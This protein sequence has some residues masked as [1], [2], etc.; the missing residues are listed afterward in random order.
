MLSRTTTPQNSVYSYD[1]LDRITSDQIDGNN[2]FQYDY[3]LNHN[4]QSKTQLASLADGYDYQLGTNRLARQ[5]T[6]TTGTLPQIASDRQYIYSDTN[7]I[8]QVY[9]NGLLT[10]EYIY[11]DNRQRTRKTTYENSVSPATTRIT[12]YHYD[13]MGY[14]I[15]ETDQTGIPQKDY[16][17]AEG[18]VPMAQI[19]IN[20][21]IDTTH[22][23]HTDHLMTPRFATDQSQQISWRWE[24]EAFGETADQSL[25]TEVNL[26]FPGQYFDIE[27]G[28]FYNWNRYYNSQIGRY[29]TSDSIGLDGGLNT[30]AYVFGNPVNFIDP[31][32]LAPNFLQKCII[33]LML[34]WCQ[35]MSPIMVIPKPVPP[36]PTTREEKSC[37]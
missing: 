9:D 3:D 1:A 14:L 17:W 11:N 33:G 6:F 26:R 31:E 20:G 25:S 2:A 23:L 30:Y 16:I 32:G 19:D 4:R 22:Y 21:G 29:I 37:K 15:A 35:D 13:T 12:L 28:E 24:G 27:T 10:A 5:A 18:M 36:P 8:F 7:R 34:L